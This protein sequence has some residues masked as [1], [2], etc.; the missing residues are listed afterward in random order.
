[1]STVLLRLP[2]KLL[3]LPFVLVALTAN[4]TSALMLVPGDIIATHYRTSKIFRV[5]PSTGELS[6]ISEGGLLGEPSGIVI[7][8]RGKGFQ[9]AIH[10][11]H[12][13]LP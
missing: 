11:T 2:R 12:G 13:N 8:S 6:T 9:H 3:V 7:N 1:M 4:T 5:D 10:E